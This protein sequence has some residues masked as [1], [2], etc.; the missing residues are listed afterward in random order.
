M[1]QGTRARFIFQGLGYNRCSMNST[2]HHGQR[3]SSS[4][5]ACFPSQSQKRSHT[6]NP[7]EEALADT[8]TQR[9]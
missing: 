2:A 9:A 4:H 1:E 6:L 8:D 3:Q 5:P 7:P